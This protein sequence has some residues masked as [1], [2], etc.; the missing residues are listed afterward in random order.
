MINCSD[1]I[2]GKQI[3]LTQIQLQ[4]VSALRLQQHYLFFDIPSFYNPIISRAQLKAAEA[5]PWKAQPTFHFGRIPVVN[6]PSS[7]KSIRKRGSN[8]EI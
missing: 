2:S 7:K 1:T 6:P 5:P 8:T 4:N 3:L